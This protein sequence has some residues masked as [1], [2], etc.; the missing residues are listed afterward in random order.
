MAGPFAIVSPRAYYV[1]GSQPYRKGVGCGPGVYVPKEQVEREVLAGL[2]ELISVCSDKKG[3]TR[4][5]NAELRRVWE[6]STGHDPRAAKRIEEI[7]RKIGNLWKAIED[8]I[9]DAA[10]ANARIRA[11]TAEREKLAGAATAVAEPP[12]IDVETALAYRRQTEKVLAKAQPAQRKQIVRAWVSEMKLAPER[13]E[14]EVTYRI[15]E[16]VMHSAIAGAVFV[17]DANSPRLPLVAARWFYAP[18]KQGARQMQR[19][20]R[21]T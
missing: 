19:L 5:V 8:G 21:A 20:G 9:S 6:E 10:T 3:F 1:C 14:V 17:P 2:R 4:Q 16:P 7:E 15:P 18:A 11:L 12:E 13:L